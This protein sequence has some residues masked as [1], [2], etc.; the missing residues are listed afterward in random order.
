MSKFDIKES[1]T[2]Y[3]N[4]VPD[5]LMRHV[6]EMVPMDMRNGEVDEEGWT[7]WKIVN[8]TI[9]MEEIEVIEQQYEIKYPELYKQF[10]RAYH[11]VELQFKNIKEGS[12]YKGDCA[13]IEMPRL[14]T[15]EGLSEVINLMENWHP[16]L[17]AGY[18]PFAVGEDGQGPICFDL[19]NP[20]EQGDYPVI[21]VL[22]DYLHQLD[23]TQQNG[24]AIR[25]F[26]HPYIRE[27]F[28]SFEEMA[29]LLIVPMRPNRDNDE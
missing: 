7:D 20:N 17:L 28:P 22:H 8:S 10:L 26:L 24:E 21:W 15:G 2:A 3:F 29:R 14:L 12:S 23:D 5:F 11:Y 1:L 25:A 19:L 16:M 6:E 27:I 18:L 9:T 13:F 4:S